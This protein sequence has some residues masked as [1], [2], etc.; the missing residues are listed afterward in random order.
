MLRDW[1]TGRTNPL[2]AATS[3]PAFTVDEDAIDPAV[4]GL[5]SYVSP[6]PSA[7]RISRREAIQVPAVKASRDLIATTLGSLPIDVYG[8]DKKLAPWAVLEQP[9]ANVP[10]SV[11]MA[12][13]FEDM[14][15]EGVAWWRVVTFGWH[16]FPTKVKRIDPRKVQVDEDSGTVR[17]NGKVVKSSELIRFDSPNDGLLKAASRAIRTCLNLDLAAGRYADGAPPVDYFTPADGFDPSEDEE[18]ESLLDAWAVARRTRSTAYVPAALKYNIAGWSPKDLQL[19]EARQHAVLEIARAARIDPEELGVS[20]TSRTYSNQFDRRKAFLDFTLGGYVTAMQDRLSMGDVTPRG[21]TARLNLDAFLRTDTKTRF[22]TYEIGLRVG[23]ITHEEIRALEDREPLDNPPAPHQEIATVEANQPA[24][25]TF[26]EGPAIRLD[27]D[28]TAAA[29]EVDTERRTIRGLAVPYGKTA[30][31]GG[32]LWQFSKGSLDYADV[33]RVKLWVQHD[34]NRAVGVATSLEDTDEG[35]LATFK[36]ARG[37]EGDR[38]LMLA[39]DGVLDGLSIG[40]ALGGKFRKTKAGINEAI[41]APLMEISLTPAPAYDD[42]RVHAVAASATN[43]TGDHDMPEATDTIEQPEADAPD[44]SAI[45]NAI[46]AGFAGL[47][48]G[49][50][51]HIDATDTLEINEPAPYRFDGIAGARSFSEDLRNAQHGDTDARQRLD[52]FFGEAF[53]VTTSGTAALNPTPTR[54]ELYVPQLHYARPLWEMVTNGSIDDKT[55]FII[56]KFNTGTGLVAAHTEGTEPTPGAFTATSQTITPTA[57]S[58]KIEVNREVLDQGGSPQTDQII[59]IEMQAAYYDAI[60]ADIAA[61]LNAVGTAESNL[62]G[63]VDSALV[64]ALK[65]ILAGLQFVRGGNRFTRLA[66]DGQLFPA[67]ID[68]NDD[69]GRPLLPVHGPSNADGEVSGAFDRVQIGGL[70]GRAAYALGSTVASKSHLFV[71]TSVFAWASAP[72]RFTFEYQVKS[73]D[74]AIWGYSAS[75]VTRESDV[76]PIDYT[77]ADS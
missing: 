27:A 19:G 67:L 16:G 57:K 4:F 44:F 75:A 65:A 37:P 70:E 62:G 24:D 22:E 47:N 49:P 68:A 34:P 26:D 51:D 53:A 69:N 5:A 71:P 36:V 58:G 18:I 61:T 74:I 15:F 45:T 29:F 54:P 20:T 33:S 6:I 60:E 3:G 7:A 9:E 10:R 1:F 52:E 17:V 63:A 21:Y 66:L 14:L 46:E 73:V 77:T 64:G 35:M 41:L 59:W 25:V 12:R 23:A 11:T 56:P 48:L 76:K 39:E 2:L 72:K 31:S 38:A 42:A 43:E 8:P 28:N 32:Q 13:T 30:R 40:L 50:R 55:P